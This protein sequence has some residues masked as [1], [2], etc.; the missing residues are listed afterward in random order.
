[1]ED[2][3]IDGVEATA[4]ER[5]DDQVRRVCCVDS[6]EKSFTESRPHLGLRLWE[7]FQLA[8]SQ[9]PFEKGIAAQIKGLN[10]ERGVAGE[11]HH[12]DAL[13]LAAA[14]EWRVDATGV[15]VEEEDGGF[16]RGAT[17]VDGRKDA[18]DHQEFK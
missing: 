5:S 9:F 11:D 16:P 18:S 14:P 17:R 10:V 3:G 13:P 7:P 12:V 6:S 8:A 2:G 4:S 15:P 1:L